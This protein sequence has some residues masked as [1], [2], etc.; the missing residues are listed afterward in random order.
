MGTETKKNVTKIFEDSEIRSVCDSEQE[1]YY[2]SVVDVI[3]VLTDS[4]RP[5]K[6]WSDLKK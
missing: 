5:R 3:K 1:D 4:D 2:W 6:Y